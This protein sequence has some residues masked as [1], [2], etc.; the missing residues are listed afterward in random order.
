MLKFIYLNIFAKSVP[1]NL[2]KSIMNK[3]FKLYPRKNST[4]KGYINIYLYLS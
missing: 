4:Q 1:F 2:A 3:M